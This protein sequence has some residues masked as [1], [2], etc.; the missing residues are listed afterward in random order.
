MAHGTS[1]YRDAAADLREELVAAAD[2][3]AARRLEVGAVRGRVPRALLRA[4]D[5]E[6]AWL[7]RAIHDR[8]SCD[9]WLR[10]ADDCER[11]LAAAHVWGESQ[12]ARARR[13]AATLRRMAPFAAAAVSLGTVPLVPIAAVR[14]HNAAASCAVEPIC[15]RQ[16]R[17][18]VEPLAGAL[19][20]DRANGWSA[21]AICVAAEPF[22]CA[23]S[24]RAVGACTPAGLEGC[25]AASEADC[26]ASDACRMRS[27]C[28]HDRELKRCVFSPNRPPRSDATCVDDCLRD[29]RCWQDARGRCGT[30]SEEECAHGYRCALF[31]ACSYRD[32][33]YDC[34]AASDDD[35]AR[36]DV[37][38][39]KG[40][41]RAE[42]GVCVP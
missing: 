42:Y 13:R 39:R 38:Q 4:I 32:G 21:T 27:E 20:G 26:R 11:M 36:S 33:S 34:A 14:W 35:C 41:C 16:G 30:A 37:C 31:G 2:R 24:C 22:Q 3:M 28:H 25:V 10:H 18:T 5:G 29:A 12:A 15:S 23:D 1:P 9:E 17:C 19:A 6:I 40:S 7:G 8:S